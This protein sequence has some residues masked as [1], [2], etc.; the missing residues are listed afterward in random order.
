MDILLEHLLHRMGDHQLILTP[1]SRM[2]EFYRQAYGHHQVN[3]G[4]QV[5]NSPTIK[6]LKV[7]L[8]ELWLAGSM[9][10]GG[11]Q[12]MLLSELQSDILWRQIIQQ[13]RADSLSI[14]GLVHGAKSAWK[15]C[16]LWQQAIDA[17]FR[18]YNQDTEAFLQWAEAYQK[19][20]DALNAIDE[21]QLM[22]RVTE[23]FSQQPLTDLNSLVFLNF[24]DIS[25]QLDTF[26]QTLVESGCKVEALNVA[27]ESHHQPRYLAYSTEAQEWEAMLSWA[28]LH[29]KNGSR[30]VCVVPQLN[31]NKRRLQRVLE[32]ALSPQDYNISL[33]QSL[34][35]YTIVNIAMLCLRLRKYN[36]SAMHV[37]E[38]LLNNYLYAEESQAY[39][40]PEVEKKWREN[41]FQDYSLHQLIQLS[42]SVDIKLNQALLKFSSIDISAQKTLA[43][44]AKTWIELLQAIGWPGSRSLHS[45]E[46]QTLECFLS[47]CDTLTTSTPLFP[48]LSYSKALEILRLSCKQTI[49]Q[50]QEKNAFL[51]VMG[52]LEASGLSFDEAWVMDMNEETLPDRVHLNPFIPKPL[53]V[54]KNMPHA[55]ADRQMKLANVSVE[56]LQMLAPKVYFSYAK[57]KGDMQYAS[58]AL[59]HPLKANHQDEQPP[60]SVCESL[61]EYDANNACP[62]GENEQVFGGSFILKDQALC[63]FRAFARHRLRVDELKEVEPGIQAFERGN[64]I[65]LALEFFWQQ[66]QTQKNLNALSSQELRQ[67]IESALG[68]A[69]D[70]AF[71]E[72][73]KDA[74]AKIH[75]QLEYERALKLLQAFIALEKQ[76]PPFEVESIE[77]WQEFELGK[78]TLRCRVDRI[79]KIEQ[80]RLIIDYKT[81][82]MSLNTW[83]GERPD[84]PQL[85]LYVSMKQGIAVSYVQLKE[86]ST[87]FK[88]MAMS[89]I[90]ILGIESIEESKYAKRTWQEQLSLWQ[91]VLLNM[92]D[93]FCA[94]LNQVSPKS[95]KV[96]QYCECLP[97]CRRFE[98]EL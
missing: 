61:V 76:R 7:W 13:D 9:R 18:H 41:N 65:H 43:E 42:E 69:L 49:F 89:D 84:E 87:Q 79:D 73:P 37:S 83:F 75:Y 88:G 36:L 46:L 97:L 29:Q 5:W 8:K 60:S 51:H 31:E 34:S 70:K 86:L 47:V 4:C 25:P 58:C 24:D 78:L 48:P 26:V 91:N 22:S 17:K 93:D 57:H 74:F 12:K 45:H 90:D 77:A 59:L 23:Q 50:P 19:Q 20:L 2:T 16:C 10:D 55:T 52:L 64:I 53:Q 14:N 44:W 62:L 67:Q 82:L 85:P 81:S 30:V 38:L 94:G 35:E 3:M 63:P 32:G 39:L 71:S 54:Q 68:K 40:W 95:A 28:K 72:R 1:N 92:A 80:G 11:S 66:L 6:P 33:G 15:T 21:W 98:Y 56:R 27:I 96:C